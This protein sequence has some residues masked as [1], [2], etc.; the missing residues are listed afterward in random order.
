MQSDGF[1][2]S[3]QGGTEGTERRV[4][5]FRRWVIAAA[6]QII[7]AHRTAQEEVSVKR[8]SFKLGSMSMYLSCGNTLTVLGSNTPVLRTRPLHFE[9]QIASNNTMVA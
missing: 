5:G 3:L 2:A 4:E 9:H 6:Q 8:K 1:D 7:A